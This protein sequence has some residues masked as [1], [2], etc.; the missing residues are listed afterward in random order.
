LELGLSPI[1]TAG[2]FLQLI[3]CSGFIQI[4]QNRRKDATFMRK[5]TKVAALLVSVAQATM[6]VFT[7]SFG[8]IKVQLTLVTFR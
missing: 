2:M 4:N 5:A 8:P 1:I 7:G 6:L 3:E